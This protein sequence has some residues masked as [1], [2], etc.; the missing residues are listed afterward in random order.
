MPRAR[1]EPSTTKPKLFIAAVALLALLMVA[2]GWWWFRGR[3]VVTVQSVAVLPFM[4]ATGNADGEF[5]SD[6]LTEDIINRLAQLPELRV[7]ARSTVLRF[8]NNS[9]EPQ[10][11]ESNWTYRACSP[12]ASHNTAIRLPSKPISSE[13]RTARKCGASDIRAKCRISP[14]FKM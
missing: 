5:L 6:G 13:F 9:D 11:L 1:N 2:G 14:R 8:K 12:A 10:K 7:L 3:T 4:N